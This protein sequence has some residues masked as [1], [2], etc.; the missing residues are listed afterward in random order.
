MVPE[1]RAD[2]GQLIAFVVPTVQ[3]VTQQARNIRGQ[4]GVNVHE[5]RGD[6]GVDFWVSILIF[7]PRRF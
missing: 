4:L 5:F 2:D 7:W 6:M 1:D 3:L